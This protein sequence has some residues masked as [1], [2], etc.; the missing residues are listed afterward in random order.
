M[1]KKK[2]SHCIEQTTDMSTVARPLQDANGHSQTCFK[3]L[4]F[5]KFTGVKHV[6]DIGQLPGT[7][8]HD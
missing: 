4:P 6:H 3:K 2:K 1:T 5:C 8:H 7:Q